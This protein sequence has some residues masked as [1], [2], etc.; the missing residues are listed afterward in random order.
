[1]KKIEE[2]F[3]IELEF[4]NMVSYVDS[5]GVRQEANSHPGMVL[6]DWIVHSVYSAM[7]NLANIDT[8]TRDEEYRES[9]IRPYQILKERNLIHLES[10]EGIVFTNEN[11]PDYTDEL[12]EIVASTNF[13]KA[14]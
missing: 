7:N 14:L 3:G 8:G 5:N 1:M 4:A 10:I 12:K 9:I 6:I 11:D 13:V 2:E